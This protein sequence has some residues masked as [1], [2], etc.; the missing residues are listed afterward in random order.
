MN[1]RQR[2][3]LFELNSLVRETLEIEM[4]DEYWV[5]AEISELREVNGHCYMNLI[6]KEEHSNTPV[7]RASAKCWRSSWVS[8]KK[9]FVQVTDKLPQQG[10]KMLLKV[11]AQFH[12]NYGFSWIVSD[13]DP[14][15]T[16]GDMAAKR[17][18]ILR[19]LEKEG[20]IDA[21]K[22]LELPLFTQRIAVI[23][24]AT[25]A[26]YGDFCNHL[27]ENEFGFSFHTE[28]FAAIMQGE[29]VER[30]V[31]TAIEM[32]EDR[33][34]GFDCIVIT[35]GGGATSDLSG[36]DTLNLARKVAYCS[37]P[38]ITAI[39]H[40]RDES[41]LDIISNKRLK[42]PTAAAAFLI[43]RLKEVDN[44]LTE[45]Y[46]RILRVV[47]HTVDREKNRFQHL[48]SRIPTLF[49]VVESKQV[50][51]LD[52]LF[53]RAVNMSSQIVM[54]RRFMLDKL[55]QTISPC[56]MRKIG[57]ET[58]RMELLTQAL[59]VL[60]PQHILDRGYSITV[61]QGRAVKDAS[62]LSEGN[63]VETRLKS[64]KFKSVVIGGK[65]NDEIV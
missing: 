43:D 61:C 3:T 14:T 48:S 33:K 36:F 46:Q 26:G 40:D 29:D 65:Q 6:Q 57:K 30:S 41:V 42:T 4:P 64:G 63:V 10:M 32:I 38:V 60:D 35:R 23:S 55:A 13:I 8:I 59:S 2:L 5:E 22:E 34:E 56:L 27:A 20:V 15:F 11:G 12:E 1:S 58:H 54:K 47:Q 37:L 25:A 17:Q 49:A 52:A 7:A 62:S 39:G 9:H 21:N 19:Q 53:M 31:I 51:K 50:A 45:S 44:R 28:L 24:S 16:L 18:Q